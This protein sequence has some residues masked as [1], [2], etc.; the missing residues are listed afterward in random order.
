VVERAGDEAL[1]QLLRL[2]TALQKAGSADEFEQANFAMLDLL[3]MAADSVPLV[4]A[5]RAMPEIVPRN[6]F[7]RVPGAMDAQRR[8][9]DDVCAAARRGDIA[10]VEVAWWSS[11][12]QV[13]A[14]V[15]NLL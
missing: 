4:S 8:G 12:R 11:M 1:Q 10:A 5:L 13:A 2:N 6:F 3:I 15:I 9:L 7:A 14:C